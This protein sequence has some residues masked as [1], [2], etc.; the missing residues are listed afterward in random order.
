MVINL[1]KSLTNCHDSSPRTF[2]PWLDQACDALANPPAHEP[3]LRSFV[4]RS[5]WKPK[6]ISSEQSPS[7]QSMLKTPND[8]TVS[9]KHFFHHTH[10]NH[11]RCCC[12]SMGLSFLH[13]HQILLFCCIDINV[14]K[15]FLTFMTT[16]LT[17]FGLIWIHRPHWQAQF[18]IAPYFQ[19][20]PLIQVGVTDHNFGKV[21]H[22]VFHSPGSWLICLLPKRLDQPS[23]DVFDIWPLSQWRSQQNQTKSMTT[24]SHDDVSNSQARL[25]TSEVIKHAGNTTRPVSIWKE[26]THISIF[27]RED[28]AHQAKCLDGRPSQPVTEQTPDLIKLRQTPWQQHMMKLYRDSQR[29]C[30]NLTG[31]VKSYSR[32]NLWPSLSNAPSATVL[33]VILSQ[34]R[35]HCILN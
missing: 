30:R 15:I 13:K 14:L 32:T 5:S 3:Q 31:L 20:F 10:D 6:S 23:V 27:L 24:T 18:L 16:Q 11:C 7:Q 8:E 2:G 33:V 12:S 17:T 35:L 28:Q 4:S 19:S 34:Y 21:S 25:N 29:T 26:G 22:C 9:A 1:S